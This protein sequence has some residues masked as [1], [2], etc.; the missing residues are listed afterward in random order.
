MLGPDRPLRTAAIGP[1]PSPVGREGADPYLAGAVDDF[2]V[3]RRALS[4][5]EVAALAGDQVGSG[6]VLHYTFDE[7]S[8]IA[9]A[10]SSGNGRTAT[11]VAGSGSQ[12]ASSDAATPDHFWVLTPQVPP[13]TTLTWSPAQ[14]N[15]NNG[16]YTTAPSFTLDAKDDF[17]VVG[18]QYRIDGGDWTAYTGS[19]VTVDQQ[20]THQ[21]EYRS[22]D[23]AGNVEATKS[24]TVKTDTVAPTA[25]FSATVGIVYFGS[26]PGAPTCTASDATSGPAGCVV[27]GYDTSVGTH[28][29]TATATDAAG[30]VGTAEQTYTVLP[31][32][33]KGFYSPVDMGGVVNTVKGGSTV[34][35]MFQVYSGT[36]ELTDPAVVTMTVKQVSCAAD[37]P[38]SEIETLTTGAT[39]LKYDGGQFHYNW[40]TP[41]TPGACYAVTAT[42]RDGSSITALFK[43]R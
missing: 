11:I 22:T 24:A 16:W 34:P 4:A 9:V 14:P 5:S 20:G 23:T 17:A 37:A 27:S 39:T 32:T 15:G 41:A 2:N 18:T 10:D 28:T 30:N 13:T 33:V 12:T 29:L 6:D 40:K 36:T 21:V 8:G 42:T 19:P 7:A 35:V 3:Y 1:G 26:V 43:L 31:W 38:T 25:A